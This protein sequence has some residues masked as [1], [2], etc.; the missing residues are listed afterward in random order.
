M[1]KKETEAMHKVRINQRN[2]TWS[3][4][5]DREAWQKALA[6]AY[7]RHQTAMCLCRPGAGLRL[8][9]R[10]RAD[11][12]HLARFPFTGPLHRRDCPYFGLEKE[13]SGRSA[14]QSGVIKAAGRGLVKIKLRHALHRSEASAGNPGPAMH[15]KG[16]SRAGQRAISTLGLLHYLW[17]QAGINL[18]HP[19]FAGRRHWRQVAYRVRGQAQSVV[20]TKGWSLRDSIVM[21]GMDGQ[22]ENQQVIARA[23]D[24][25]RRFFVLGLFTGFREAQYNQ[26]VKLWKLDEEDV[27]LWADSRLVEDVKRRFPMAFSPEH[28]ESED[29]RRV[30]LLFAE[31]APGGRNAKVLDM[32]VMTCSWELVPVESSYELRLAKG[33][34]DAKRHFSKPLR[35]DS[36]E[37]QVLPDFLLLDTQPDGEGMPLE[38]FGM[39]TAEYRRRKAEKAAYYIQHYR[40]NAP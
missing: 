4:A 36:S 31:L 20:I 24:L 16:P 32:V 12:Y 38:V 33:L 29:V 2:F 22:K 34:V 1:R 37:D 9:I 6:A 27:A 14:Y 11:K 17:E 39:D 19:G 18:W 35:F 28:A 30:A 13:L 21:V 5:T 40:R 15:A 8:S 23:L 3:N 25:G 26:A 7:S 10:R